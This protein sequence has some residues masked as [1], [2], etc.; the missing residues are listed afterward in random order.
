MQPLPDY[1]LQLMSPSVTAEFAN[2]VGEALAAVASCTLPPE[3]FTNPLVRRRVV[4]PAR[5]A[6]AGLRACSAS[7]G[8]FPVKVHAGFVGAMMQALPRMLDRTSADGVVTKGYANGL[9]GL[10]G[11]HSFDEVGVRDGE[12]VGSADALRLSH[13]R[14]IRQCLGF[15]FAWQLACAATR[16]RSPSPQRAP[17]PAW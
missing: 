14:P 5:Y 2:T 12:E 10:L 13:G 3:A 4:A 6:G 17:C 8:I 11:E 7:E 15:G 9:Q 1:W 16:G